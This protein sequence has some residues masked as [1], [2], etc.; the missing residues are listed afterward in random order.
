MDKLAV[1]SSVL[2]PLLWFV[3]RVLVHWGSPGRAENQSR[4]VYISLTEQA[5]AATRST[6][7]L[8]LFTSRFV[9]M[10]HK[11]VFTLFA[12]MHNGL[13]TSGDDRVGR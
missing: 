8:R 13:T 4:H 3:R 5:L 10:C 11:S 7:A 12:E 1:F 9:Y 6:A 2:S